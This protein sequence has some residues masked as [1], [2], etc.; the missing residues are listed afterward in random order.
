MPAS[1]KKVIVRKLS[2]EWLSGYLPSLFP[3]EE[4]SIGLLDLDG[5]I[6]SVLLEEVKWICF[7]REFSSP[8]LNDPEH[9]RMK[10]FLRR[11]RNEG[12]WLRIRLKDNDCLEGLAQNDATLLDR[13][14]LYL[15]PPDSRS[16]TQRLFIP[17]LAVKELEILSVIHVKGP[18][19]GADDTQDLPAAGLR[20]PRLFE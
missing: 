17:R 5:K 12:L 13:H 11:P 7:V 2:Q 4:E 15:A 6:T 10:A 20:Q 18:R 1:R 16:N 19:K 14:G 3:I 8:S 9:L